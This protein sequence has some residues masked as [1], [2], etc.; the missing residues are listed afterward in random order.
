MDRREERVL[1]HRQTDLVFGTKEEVLV[2]T[3]GHEGSDEI[4]SETFHMRG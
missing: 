3:R 2:I 1:Y 4:D